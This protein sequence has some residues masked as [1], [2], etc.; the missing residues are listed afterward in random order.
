[1]GDDAAEYEGGQE[2]EGDDEAVEEAVVASA[3]A[4]P[5]PRAVVVE[6]L[7]NKGQVLNTTMMTRGELK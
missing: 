7:W 5:H 2:G 6:P 4:V 3:D 1:M